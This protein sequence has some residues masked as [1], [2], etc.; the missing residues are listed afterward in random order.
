MKITLPEIV[1][2]GLYDSR[3]AVKGRTVTRPRKTTMFELELP[4]GE[5]GVSY[6]NQHKREIDPAGIICAKPGQSRYTKLPYRCYY[7]HMILRE[8]P[9]YDYLLELPD[10]IYTNEHD[11]YE[12]LFRRLLLWYETG[13][14]T[15]EL[16]V[17]SILLELIHSLVINAR[18]RSYYDKVKHSHDEMIANVIG[19]IK[20]NLTADLSLKALAEYA[21]FSP[22]HFHHCFKASTGQTLRNFVE[23]QRIKK[24]A[25]LLTTTQ[26]TLTEIAYE[27]GFSSQ[28]YFSYAFKRKMKSTPREYAREMLKRYSV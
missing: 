21:G 28:S 23:E 6:I 3:I 16:A 12:T 22:A 14:E 20:E 2:V 10:Y 19:Y 9:L 18:K 15:D 5:G 27:C 4:L 13:L 8:G 24:A 26:Y 17:Q 11:Y 25:N 1:A 7:I